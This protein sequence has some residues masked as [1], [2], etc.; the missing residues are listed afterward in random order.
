M[1]DFIFKTRYTVTKDS[2]VQF[3]FYQPIGHQWRQTDFFPCAVTCGGEKSPVGAKL[4]WLK[5]AQELEETRIATEE[6][7]ATQQ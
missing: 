2:V 5:Q 3:F 7:I 4:P 6:P 1:A